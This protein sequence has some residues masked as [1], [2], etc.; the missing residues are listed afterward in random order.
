MLRKCAGGYDNADERLDA[1]MSALSAFVLQ[2]WF[3]CL[4][5]AAAGLAAGVWLDALARGLDRR[6]RAGRR[7]RSVDRGPRRLAGVLQAPG[8]QATRTG[9]WRAATRSPSS[10][11]VTGPNTRCGATR[12]RGRSTA[13]H[14]RAAWS[15]PHSDANWTPWRRSSASGRRPTSSAWLRNSRPGSR[16]RRPSC[17]PSC[18]AGP[19]YRPAGRTTPTRAILGRGRV[20]QATIVALQRALVRHGEAP[21]RLVQPHLL[22]P[23]RGHDLQ[24][25]PGVNSPRATLL[26]FLAIVQ[27]YLPPVRCLRTNGRNSGVGG[28]SLA[29]L[30]R[31]RERCAPWRA[32]APCPQ[33]PAPMR[34]VC[35]SCEAVYEIP[36]RLIGTGR[37]LR[38]T[39]CSHE[40]TLLPAVAEAPET[41]ASMAERSSSA[42]LEFV[43]E[44]EPPRSSPS[45]STGAPDAPA[46]AAGDR[47]AAAGGGR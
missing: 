2:T 4:A 6:G 20:D 5:T 15:G 7:R 43:S 24:K 40:W 25:E 26:R 22:R 42:A 13:Y 10:C 14:C 31:R 30:F 29:F 18:R 39:K 33:S 27:S 32:P 46:P 11:R 16:R 47:P 23:D 37:R 34:A 1:A 35:P 28:P 3:L 12:G 41:V 21:S 17:G 45:S 19:A 44:A 38:C 36:D 8:A 9:S